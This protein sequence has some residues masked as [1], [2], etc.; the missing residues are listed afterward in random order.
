MTDEKAL[1]I[2]SSKKATAN[3]RK[4]MDCHTY[5]LKVDMSQLSK[6][7]R[8]TLFMMFVEA[9]RVHNNII[10]WI[11]EGNGINDYNCSVKAEVIVRNKNGDYESKKLEY[12]PS[13]CIQ[14]IKDEVVEALKS[15]KTHKE[16][17]DKTGKL[18][19]KADHYC[20]TFCQLTAG[21]GFIRGKHTVKI[22]KVD[23]LVRVNGLDQMQSYMELAEAQVLNTP[24]GYYIHIV[25]YSP[26]TSIVTNGKE[27]GIDFGIKTHLTFSTGEKRNVLVEETERLKKRQRSVARKKKGS[28][29]RRKARLLLEREYQKLTNQKNEKAN[30]LV[31]EILQYDHVYMQDEQ[32]RGWAKFAFGKT[33]QHS[34]LGRV[35]AKLIRSDRVTVLDKWVPTS[36]LCICGRK[37]TDLTL[38]DRMFKCNYCDYE[39][40][41]DVHAAKNMIRLGKLTKEELKDLLKQ[42]DSLVRQELAEF[43][44]M[45]IKPSGMKSS[46][47]IHGKANRRS[48]KVL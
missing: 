10:R 18:K 34:V 26:K 2:A 33:I 16:K 12:L 5:Q 11:D 43:T 35:K 47:A 32:L 27:L 4:N 41:R 39:E 28:N 7:Q 22:P 17:G 3:R 19:Y 15:L 38:A 9:K 42:A 44:P 25:T 46:K 37:K 40:D 36:R 45:E 1:R 24:K 13:G 31:H 14:D 20:L 21:K 8:N 23:G 6:K 29:N 30:Q 48:G